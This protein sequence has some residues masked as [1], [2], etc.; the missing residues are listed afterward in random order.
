MT[1]LFQTFQPPRADKGPL[2]S[3]DIEIEI[4]ITWPTTRR[5]SLP[6]YLKGNFIRTG[7][8]IYEFG[9]ESFKHF[10]DPMAI[11][12]KMEFKSFGPIGPSTVTYS[13]AIVQSTHFVKNE[14]E[15]LI[16]LIHNL[17]ERPVIVIIQP[18]TKLSDLKL[19][20]MVNQ[21]R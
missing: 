10:F 20:P 16:R 9:K 3:L 2:D 14:G 1:R 21:T 4:E 5:G 17:R 11:L 12:Q 15:H 8:G 19:E 6:P 18:R 13:A 7:P